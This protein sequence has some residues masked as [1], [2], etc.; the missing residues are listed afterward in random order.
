MFTQA[1]D[2]ITIGS[3]HV[4]TGG[5]EIDSTMKDPKGPLWL[6]ATLDNAYPDVWGTAYIHRLP[7]SVNR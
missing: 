5:R 6:A 2:P 7:C 4:G 1:T 3:L